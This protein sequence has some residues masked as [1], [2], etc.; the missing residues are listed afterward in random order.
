M[1]RVK[2]DHRRRGLASTLLKVLLDHVVNIEDD[3]LTFSFVFPAFLTREIP[4]DLPKDEKEKLMDEK[5]AA[6]V[7]PFRKAGFRRVGDSAWFAYAF[8][9]SHSSR[10]VAINDD[11]N[12]PDPPVPKT[13]L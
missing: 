13:P 1:I 3:F 9:D 4:D 2:E 5:L 11:Y 7:G 10:L 8:D 6:A 12:P